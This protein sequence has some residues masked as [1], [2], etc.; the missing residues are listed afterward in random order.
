MYTFISWWVFVLSYKH[1]AFSMTLCNIENNLQQFSDSK[2]LQF[3]IIHRSWSFVTNIKTVI[4]IDIDET[5]Y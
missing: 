4:F 2:H 5:S 3:H 1:I